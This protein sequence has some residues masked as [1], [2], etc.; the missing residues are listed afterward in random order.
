MEDL[1]H[2]AR[3][4]GIFSA[5]FPKI[6][7]KKDKT[8]NKKNKNNQKCDTQTRIKAFNKMLSAFHP[9][10]ELVDYYIEVVYS[11]KNIQP[12]QSMIWL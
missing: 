4:L 7:K 9:S 5:T 2:K 6:M 8:T 10:E 1:V 12:R 11:L 3:H